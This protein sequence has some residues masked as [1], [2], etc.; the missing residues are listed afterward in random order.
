MLPD[1]ETQCHNW[2]YV[3]GTDL[4]GVCGWNHG[5]DKAGAAIACDFTERLQDDSRQLG[6][7]PHVEPAVRLKL[8]I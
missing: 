6:P 2:L 7:L 1:I 3:S 5:G 8:F 4:L